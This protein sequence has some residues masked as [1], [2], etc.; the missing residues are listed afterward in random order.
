MAAMMVL[1]L[2]GRISDV[3]GSV[4]NVGLVVVVLG[5]LVVGAVVYARR[6]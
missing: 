6:R 3:G 5:L 2:G 1:M 4:G